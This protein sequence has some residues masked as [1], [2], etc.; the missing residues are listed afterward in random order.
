MVINGKVQSLLLAGECAWSL[1]AINVG[2]EYIDATHLGNDL[3]PE[4]RLV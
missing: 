3:V 2:I 1:S 4:L